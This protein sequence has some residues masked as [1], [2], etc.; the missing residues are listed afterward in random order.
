MKNLFKLIPIIFLIGCG[1]GGGNS[2]PIED[3]ITKIYE[4]TMEIYKPYIVTTGDKVVKKSPDAHIKITHTEGDINSTV[5]L[6]EG[7]ANLIY[8]TPIIV[9][10]NTTEDNNDIDY[11]TIF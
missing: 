7:S 2:T 11:N 9:E 5:E 6:I 4:I 8:L 1:G 3:E 10:N